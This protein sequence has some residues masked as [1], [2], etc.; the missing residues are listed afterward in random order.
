MTT[1][2]LIIT[3]LNIVVFDVCEGRTMIRLVVIS[4]G[5]INR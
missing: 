4:V 5:V 1:V 2:V 3:S